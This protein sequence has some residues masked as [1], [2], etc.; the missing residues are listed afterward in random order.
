MIQ[1]L[2][3]QNT[4]EK[5]PASHNDGGRMNAKTFQFD[6]FFVHLSKQASKS[7]KSEMSWTALLYLCYPW[8]L[9]NLVLSLCFLMETGTLRSVKRLESLKLF[10]GFSVGSPPNGSHFI[11]PTVVF[12]GFHYRMF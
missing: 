10:H 2:L 6:L 7:V 12:N 8:F 5:R 1:I 9:G 3:N 11:F 4:S